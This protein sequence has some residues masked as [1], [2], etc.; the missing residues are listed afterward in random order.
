[1]KIKKNPSPRCDTER[2]IRSGYI[3]KSDLYQES[4]FRTEFPTK[5]AGF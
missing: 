2:K 1:M 3:Q 4:T 5:T